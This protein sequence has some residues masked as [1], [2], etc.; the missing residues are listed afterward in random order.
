MK[1]PLNAF[2]VFFVLSCVLWSASAWSATPFRIVGLDTYIQEEQYLLDFDAHLTLEGEPKVALQSGVPL[3]FNIFLKLIQERRY[4]LDNVLLEKVISYRLEYHD[5]TRRYRVIELESGERLG[6]RS[7]RSAL[8]Y[9]ANL[10]GYPL[11]SKA[12]ASRYKGAKGS[13]QVQLDILRL[14]LPLRPKA[15]VS[16]QWRLQTKVKSWSVE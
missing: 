10:T 2:A 7:L 15:Y 4:W 3:Y 11:L 14:P 8:D 6:F 5:L 9:I 12:D 13:L 16:R 1:A